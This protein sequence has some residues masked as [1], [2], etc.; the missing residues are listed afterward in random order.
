MKV[1]VIIPA[2][3]L[4][5][6]WLRPRLQDQERAPSK[7]FKELGGVPILVHTLRQFAA[8]PAV[9]EIVVALRKDEI[10]GFRAQLEKQYPEILRK[11]G[12]GGGRRT[13]A[14]FGRHALR[15]SLQ[16]PT[17]S[18]SSTTPCARL[19]L[20]RYPRIQPAE[21][22]MRQ[23]RVCRRRHRKA[24][25][26]HRRWR[27]HQGDDSSRECGHGANPARLSL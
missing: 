18:C 26:S 3:G 22:I 21:S 27:D 5:R 12:T 8:A 7:Q 9:H 4:A 16:I 15:A 2:A 6:A 19:S 10:A 1:F 11:P 17:T 13:S 24:G 20:P 25:R 23:L 14:R